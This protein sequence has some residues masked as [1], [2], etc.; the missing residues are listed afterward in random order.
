VLEKIATVTKQTHT[1]LLIPERT[2]AI[3]TD[4]LA[5]A[6]DIARFSFYSLPKSKTIP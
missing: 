5:D 6:H 1:V 4:S 2:W 3:V